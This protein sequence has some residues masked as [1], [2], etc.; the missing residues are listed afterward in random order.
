MS[1]QLYNNKRGM[2]YIQ[3]IPGKN[4]KQTNM[5]Q[6]VL[7]ADGQIAESAKQDRAVWR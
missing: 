6:R 4:L 5:D 3:R 1:L 2:Q 7:N